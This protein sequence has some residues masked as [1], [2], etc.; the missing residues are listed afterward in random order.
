LTNDKQN[1]VH[2]RKSIKTTF[3]ISAIQVLLCLGLAGCIGLAQE[4]AGA[5]LPSQQPIQASPTATKPVQVPATGTLKPVAHETPSSPLTVSDLESM[6]V[7]S[8]TLTPQPPECLVQGGRIEISSLRSSR[9]PLPME[10]RV[11]LPPCYDEQPDQRYPVLYLIH[12]QNYNEDQWDRLG[13]DE[14]A[15]RLQAKGKLPA[16]IIV[17]PRDRYWEEPEDSQFDEVFID[18]LMPRIAQEYRTREEREQ[19]AIGGLSRGAA[20]AVHL[21][22]TY[23]DIFGSLGAHSLPVFWSDAARLRSRLDEI[24]RPLLPRIYLDIGDQDRPP[25]LK[26]AIWFESLLGEKAI[27]HEWH[28]FPGF[29]E[30]AYW[31]A[32]LQD[33]LSWYAAEW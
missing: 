25:I 4:A 2:P 1:P 22:L 13:V 12:G 24:P 31:Q 19:R 29:H 9:L 23:P 6:A 33:Y 28:L 11:Y 14:T 7:P 18:E 20:W 10:Y 21:G 5:I 17:M 30:E 15:S 32:H 27:S 8:S 3:W 26:S 16:F